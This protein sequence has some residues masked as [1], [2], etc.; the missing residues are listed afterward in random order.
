MAPYLF[1]LDNQLASYG[2]FPNSMPYVELVFL[3]GYLTY[4]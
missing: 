2:T 4:S 1:V 3:D